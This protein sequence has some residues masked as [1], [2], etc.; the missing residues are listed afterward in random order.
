MVLYAK[1][2]GLQSESP[3]SIPPTGGCLPDLDAPGQGFLRLRDPEGQDAVGVF[4]F[5]IAP[6]PVPREFEG[7]GK[8]AVG[9]FH[10]A[11]F[12]LGFLINAFLVAAY[13]EAVLL[14][15]DLDVLLGNARQLG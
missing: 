2:T 6:L 12:A 9:G 5:D 13:G 4:G 8:G 1:R 15:L 14:Y 11:V 3:P 7:A 10:V